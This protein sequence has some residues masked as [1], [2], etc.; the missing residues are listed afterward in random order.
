M[1]YAGLLTQTC[2]I[3]QKA[4]AVQSATG[5]V[6]PSYTDRATGVACL[7]QPDTQ[8]ESVDNAQSGG[9]MIGTLFLPVGTTIAFNDRINMTS[10]VPSG[11]QWDVIGPKMDE[12]GRGSTLSVKVRFDTAS[13]YE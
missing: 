12:A 13:V 11:Q 1:S 7:L 5:Y 8:T 6:K 9:E 4:E 2:T 3:R 10:G